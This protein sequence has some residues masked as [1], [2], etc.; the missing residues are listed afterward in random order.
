[1]V[2]TNLSLC[3]S[4][5]CIVKARLLEYL[6]PMDRHTHKAEY[7]TV[8]Q[9]LLTAQNISILAIIIQSRGKTF[10]LNPVRRE[11][12]PRIT[13][14]IRWHIPFFLSRAL[15]SFS[16]CKLGSALEYNMKS[17]N[18]VLCLTASTAIAGNNRTN[19]S[20]D[21]SSSSKLPVWLHEPDFTPD[22]ILRVT[23]NETF[24]V[25]CQTRA[26]VLVN[27]TSPGPSLYFEPGQTQWIRVYNDMTT[28]NFTMVS[29]KQ[30]K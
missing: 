23:L 5:T 16:S 24:S 18:V 12:N 14:F 1:M 29:M 28:E 15:N 11:F 26:T 25:A 19:T 22:H 7:D 3:Q 9:S 27:G 20:S 8:A 13:L 6:R 2:S 30:P 17:T 4:P 10:I 21:E